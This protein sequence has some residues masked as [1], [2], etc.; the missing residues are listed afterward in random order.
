MSKR[1]Y[2]LIAVVIAAA[3]AAGL[4][5]GSAWPSREERLAARLARAERAATE[6]AS[7]PK[8]TSSSTQ[9][10][11]S[12]VT[13]V[14]LDQLDRAVAEVEAERLRCAY[15]ADELRTALLAVGLAR[16]R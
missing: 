12:P 16:R 9:S 15:A 8:V 1:S 13:V 7:R 11:N 6:C 5:V 10:E 3:F 14:Q 4:A 2:S